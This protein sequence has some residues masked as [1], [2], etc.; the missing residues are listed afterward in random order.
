MIWHGVRVRFGMIH[1]AQK[2]CSTDSAYSKPLLKP[3]SVAR[4]ELNSQRVVL[5]TDDHTEAD[6][7][8]IMCFKDADGK[9]DCNFLNVIMPKSSKSAATAFDRPYIRSDCLVIS[10][11]R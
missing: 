5:R 4:Y 8:H 9:L 7:D 10:T 6:V 3:T 1:N 11:P 2:N